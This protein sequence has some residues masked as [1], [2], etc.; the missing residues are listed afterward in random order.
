MARPSASQGFVC[1][2]CLLFV[3]ISATRVGAQNQS[4]EVVDAVLIGPDSRLY[5]AGA[6][7]RGVQGT[8]TIRADLSPDGAFLNPTVQES[9]RSE[10]LDA[11]ALALVPRLKYTQTAEGGQ[12][13][14]ALVVPID[15]R[16]DSLTTL[17]TKTCADFNLDATYFKSAFPDLP[18]ADMPVFDLMTGILALSVDADRRLTLAPNLQQIK[19]HVIATCREAPSS[20]FMD[21]AVQ[22]AK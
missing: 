17:M 12:P 5:P 6:A 13:P 21:A 7:E 18:L 3:V 1:A 8:V 4:P 20:R 19:E 2:S 10:V 14:S 11:A 16:K 15:F 9:S 22:A